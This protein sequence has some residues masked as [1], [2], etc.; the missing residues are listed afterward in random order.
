MCAGTILMMRIKRV[1][2]S[3]NDPKWGALGSVGQLQNFPHTIQVE[4]SDHPD[5]SSL[6]Q[7]PLREA[8][9]KLSIRDLGRKYFEKYQ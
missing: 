7:M 6:R 4:Y 8:E 5:C 3:L 1:V 9:T 2:I